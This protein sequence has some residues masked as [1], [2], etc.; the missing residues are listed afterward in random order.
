M[1]C[2]KEESKEEDQMKIRLIAIAL[3]FGSACFSQ[4]LCVPGSPFCGLIEAR[5]L[6]ERLKM[7]Q[8]QTQ[9]QEDLMKAQAAAV[10]AQTEQLRL[11]TEQMKQQPAPTTQPQQRDPVDSLVADPEFNR[12]PMGL[13]IRFVRLVAPE[14]AGYSEADVA[15]ALSGIALKVLGPV[16]LNPASVV[17]KQ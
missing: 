17:P 11:Q 16:A 12:L 13:R 4:Q 9:A 6:A 7:E 1:G 10:R 15:T 5:I 14:L 3:L 8:Q 2:N